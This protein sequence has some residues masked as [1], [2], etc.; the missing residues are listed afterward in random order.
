M[1][2]QDLEGKVALVTGGSFGIGRETVLAYVKNKAKVAIVDINEDGANKLAE[3][4]KALGG[5]VIVIKA[6][7]ASKTDVQAMVDKVVAHF[8][9]LDIAFNNAGID[10]SHKYLADAEEDEFDAMMNV[11]VRGVWLCMK[12]EIQQ[13]LKQGG[14]VI[15]NT[16]SIGGVLAAP[17]MGIYGATKHAVIGLT[18]TA[19][20]EYGRKGIRVNSVC[21]GVINTE[22]T[23][24]VYANDPKTEQLSLRAHPIGRIG[25]PEDIA[26]GVMYLSSDASSFMLGHQLMIEG[27]FTAL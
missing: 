20:V 25:E 8:G 6:D 2:Y 4:A 18:K 19:A 22:M 15:V 7:V 10:L 3:E 9:R 17:K 1:S 27:G 13:M 5:D 21:P 26:N 24:K 23:Q 14:G 11:N 12:Y 16:A